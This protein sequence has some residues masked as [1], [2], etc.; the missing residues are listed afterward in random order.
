[1]VTPEGASGLLVYPERWVVVAFPE[2]SE[3]PWADLV[4]QGC[5]PLGGH[6]WLVAE[7]VR[8]K[9]PE[10]TQAVPGTWARV[11]IPGPFAKS[12]LV[13]AA[14]SALAEVE[15]PALAVSRARGL[16]LFVPRETLGRALAALR[17]ARLERFAPKA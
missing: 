5:Q 16:W 1:M 10:G 9:F 11:E 17:Q 4:A 3:P 8:E 6:T 2:G 14:T 12:E 7:A 15:V 13:S